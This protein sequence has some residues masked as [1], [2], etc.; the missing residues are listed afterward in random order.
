MSG[1]SG[2]TRHQTPLRA[3]TAWPSLRHMPDPE[4][5]LRLMLLSLTHHCH[6]KPAW[7]QVPPGILPQLPTGPHLH[8]LSQHHQPSQTLKIQIR[9]QRTDW[10]LP[11]VGCVVSEGGQ[12]EQTS[13]Y[14]INESW[15]CKLRHGDY[16]APYCAAHMKG[17]KRAD[18]QSSHYA[19]RLELRMVTDINYTSCGDHLPN[20]HT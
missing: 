19:H 11:Q 15:V 16:T 5:A 9:E 7:Q 2:L 3:R 1:L 4:I 18:P 10:W 6:P 8:P 20:R 17:A 12:K 13:S 14:K